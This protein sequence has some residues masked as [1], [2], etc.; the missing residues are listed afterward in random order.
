MQI[1]NYIKSQIYE[2]VFEI[3]KNGN[4]ETVIDAY[5]GAGLLSAMLAKVSKKVYGIEIIKEAVENANNLATQNSLT[6]LT[7]ICGD[8]T[9][10]LSK[11]VKEKNISNVCHQS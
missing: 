5:S 10:E 6:N 7:N 1:N 8:C 3:V 9:I 2:K 4:F 11:L